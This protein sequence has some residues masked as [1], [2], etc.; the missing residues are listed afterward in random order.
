MARSL[1]ALD[2]NEGMKALKGR[3]SRSEGATKQR[4]QA[5]LQQSG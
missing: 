3:V 2:R 1:I 5:L 4:L